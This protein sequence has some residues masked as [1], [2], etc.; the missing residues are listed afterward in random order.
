MNDFSIWGEEDEAALNE[1]V[2]YNGISAIEV[3]NLPIPSRKIWSVK[4]QGMQLGAVLQDE[5]TK[6]YSVGYK[7]FE[8]IRHAVTYSASL[9]GIK[10]RTVIIKGDYENEQ[11]N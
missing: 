9:A 7:K 5:K 8:D 2:E 10:N 1:F 3:K 4:C 11:T 6:I